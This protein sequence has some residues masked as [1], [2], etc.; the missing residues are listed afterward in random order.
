MFLL[1]YSMLSRLTD[2]NEGETLKRNVFWWIVMICLLL[3]FYY[4]TE[5]REKGFVYRG[6]AIPFTDVVHAQWDGHWSNTRLKIKLK[7]DEQQLAF[8]VPAELAPVIENYLQAN[9]PKR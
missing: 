3:F 7:N 2:V 8:A 9:F 1:A 4:S 5:W 6:K